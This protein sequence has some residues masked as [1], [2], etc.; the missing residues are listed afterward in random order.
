MS[1]EEF[2]SFNASP[3]ARRLIAAKAAQM[4]IDP[5]ALHI[6]FN[7]QWNLDGRE[8]AWIGFSEVP[9]PDL[10][11]AQAAG[12]MHDA[13]ELDHRSLLA[14]IVKARER[15]DRRAVAAAFAASLV[16]QRLDTRSTLG[17]LAHA[18][19]LGSHR[20]AAEDRA[21]DCRECG[22]PKKKTI[23]VNHYTFRRLMWAGN[24]CQGDLGY[25]LCDLTA[26]PAPDADYGKPEKMLLK[27]IFSAIRKL[28]KTAGLTELEKSL[29]GV[30]PSNKHERQVVL[31]ILGYCG[32]LKPKDSPSRHE[33]WVARWELPQPT[34]FFR[35]EWRSPVNCWTGAD[36]LND[37][38]IDFW[39]EGL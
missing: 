1:P 38:A 13:L 10:E 2:W 32:I 18:L 4:G 34:H 19:Y 26:F 36:G 14:R 7:T 17:S 9:P 28:P 12:L 15:T 35:K 23:P 21:D 5:K 25:V 11:Y 31:E 30:F 8:G 29:S 6:L 24:V 3:K 33:R 20:F 37:A 39:F 27:K 16:T 22:F